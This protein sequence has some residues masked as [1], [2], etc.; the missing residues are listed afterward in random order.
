MGRIYCFLD[1]V[2]SAVVYIYDLGLCHITTPVLGQILLARNCR[3]VLE[4]EHNVRMP[5]GMKPP[6]MCALQRFGTF[7]NKRGW[8]V[9][10]T[11][12]R[13]V[14]ELAWQCQPGTTKPTY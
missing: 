11:H 3:S 14:R 13:H 6:R 2:T 12:M 9:L 1:K 8:T 7:E 10:G 4:S 5:Q